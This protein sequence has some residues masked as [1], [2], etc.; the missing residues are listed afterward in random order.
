MEDT[1]GEH[2]SLQGN[3]M[4]ITTQDNDPVATPPQ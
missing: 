4:S 3:A 1:E 2:V